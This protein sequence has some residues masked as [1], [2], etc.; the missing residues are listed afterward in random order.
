MAV[1]Q[2][3]PE[4][5]DTRRMKPRILVACEYSG[6]VRDAFAARGWDAWSC[7]LLPS[8]TSGNHYT[9]DVRNMLGEGW[10]HQ[11]DLL[12]AHP[13]CTY[14]SNSGVRWLYNTDGTRNEQRWT[15][16]ADAA[17]F[18]N[19]FLSTTVPHVA[20]ENPVMHGH[21]ATLVGGRASQFV[22][23][24]HFGVTETK[25]T[26]LRLVNLPPLVATH[27]V[28][29]EMRLLPKKDTHK[30]HYA[31]PGKDRWKD[32]SR[33]YPV[34]AQAMADQWGPVVEDSL[35]GRLEAVTA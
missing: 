15:D 9:G 35:V 3:H 21:G 34:I 4:R 33:T 22:Q 10:D 18:F 20:V 27:D 6:T 11:W 16:M 32:R 12:I 8:E 17:E 28:E 14:L 1:R 26:G 7:D 30:V 25:R 2:K 5:T 19:L 13:P 24:Y 29:A 31:S 23:P